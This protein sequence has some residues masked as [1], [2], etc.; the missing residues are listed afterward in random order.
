MNT[1][2]CLERCLRLLNEVIKG[3]MRGI[4]ASYEKISTSE[5]QK[6]AVTLMRAHLERRVAAGEEQW[7]GSILASLVEC[8]LY[9]PSES[10]ES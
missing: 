10:M 5:Q 8:G 4:K 6:H 7:R 3:N 1:I 9:P 2:R